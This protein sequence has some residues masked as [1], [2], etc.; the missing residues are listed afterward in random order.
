[1]IDS[2]ELIERNVGA[3]EGAQKISSEVSS[4]FPPR[5]S[6][7]SYWERKLNPNFFFL[8]L[9][10]HLQDIPA[11]IL[12]YPAKK[13]GFHGPHPLTWRKLDLPEDIRTKK[14]GF[15]FLFLA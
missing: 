6:L 3:R 5:L 11:K 1:M 8:K 4:Y 2:E 7:N 12:G 15:G 10:G 9:F 14:F 13:F